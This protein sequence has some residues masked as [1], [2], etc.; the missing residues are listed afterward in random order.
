MDYNIQE[1]Q[2]VGGVGFNC[3]YSLQANSPQALDAK[4]DDASLSGRQ[5]WGAYHEDR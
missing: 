1:I 4:H 3:N 2:A 5:C